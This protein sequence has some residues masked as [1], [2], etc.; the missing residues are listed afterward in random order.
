VTPKTSRA[1]LTFLCIIDALYSQGNSINADMLTE[2]K[3]TIRFYKINDV[4]PSYILSN[5]Y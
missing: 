3:S 1:R 5:I 2:G 4:I